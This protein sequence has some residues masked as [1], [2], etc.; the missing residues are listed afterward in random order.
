MTRVLV[1]EDSPST[2]DV[3]AL[4]LTEISHL[5]VFTAD[6]NFVG[7]LNPADPRWDRVGLLL[8]DL[9]LP[10]VRGVEIMR[11]CRRFRPDTVIFAMTAADSAALEDVAEARAVADD[12]VRKPDDVTGLADKA[13]TVMQLRA[14]RKGGTGASDGIG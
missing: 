8:C 7:L 3:L 5:D 4:I 10:D 6:T 9:M 11:A 1:V 13:R 2:R 14:A 12:F